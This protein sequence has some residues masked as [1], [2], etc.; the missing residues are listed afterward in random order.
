MYPLLKL[1]NGQYFNFMY[2]EILHN[3][4][5]YHEMAKL[6]RYHTDNST[7]NIHWCDFNHDNSDSGKDSESPKP[8]YMDSSMY[9]I[10]FKGA[11]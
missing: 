7:D 5:A 10:G 9:D 4:G 3:E 11:N 6:N 1:I 8:V 2:P